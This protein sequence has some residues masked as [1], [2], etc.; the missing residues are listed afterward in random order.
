M[1]QH[2]ISHRN[3]IRRIKCFRIVFIVLST[4]GIPHM[5]RFGYPFHYLFAIVQEFSLQVP[6]YHV[7]QS[8]EKRNAYIASKNRLTP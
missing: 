1:A 6:M 2:Y 7:H 4:L 5:L 3:V 8:S